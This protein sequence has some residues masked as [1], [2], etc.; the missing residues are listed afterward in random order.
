MLEF[1]FDA[2]NLDFSTDQVKIYTLPGLEEKVR[3]A[4]ECTDTIVASNRNKW[5]FKPPPDRYF[6]LP[7]THAIEVKNADNEKHEQ[8]HVNAFSFFRD[9]RFSYH[10]HN[11]Y[12]DATPIA[13]HHS[14]D[15]CFVIRGFSQ[16]LAIEMSEKFWQNYKNVPNFPA[17]FE[18]IV[19]NLFFSR[20][21][22]LTGC[23]RFN[24]TYGAFESYWKL[25]V[26]IAKTETPNTD[27]GKRTT[28]GKRWKVVSDYYGLPIP[29]EYI[30]NI[31]AMRNELEHESMIG[32]TAKW[33]GNRAPQVILAHLMQRW[34]NTL[35]VIMIIGKELDQKPIPPQLIWLL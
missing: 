10:E 2:H 4:E 21:P 30:E 25:F 12:I 16:E 33:Y 14:S 1:G 19:Y 13:Q 23:E 20:V 9:H 7:K 5:F 6:S 17:I 32:G 29:T 18:T 35:L 24:Q 26:P 28:H 8:F 31:V 11:G 15:P 3:Q 34:I 27:I 22:W